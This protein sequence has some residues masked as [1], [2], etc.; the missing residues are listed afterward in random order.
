MFRSQLVISYNAVVE[1][2]DQVER[3]LARPYA[4]A[5]LIFKPAEQSA[6]CRSSC[7]SG[8]IPFNRVVFKGCGGESFA[9]SDHH[10][11]ALVIGKRNVCCRCR[12]V[13]RLYLS[14]VVKR[15]LIC[16]AIGICYRID[17]LIN[18]LRADSGFEVARSIC[19]YSIRDP[20]ISVSEI[21]RNRVCDSSER[22]I[23]RFRIGRAEVIG[24]CALSRGC[25][26]ALHPV[27]VAESSDSVEIK[28]CGNK[29]PGIIRC[30]IIAASNI[31]S[32]ASPTISSGSVCLIITAPVLRV[33]VCGLPECRVAVRDEYNV[34]I[35]SHIFRASS[36]RNIR[37]IL[38]SL[39][40]VCSAFRIHTV[41]SIF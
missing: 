28:T 25:N 31:S 9:Y 32:T 8:H 5:Y 24:A 2:C 26:E 15:D 30:S 41:N 17:E 12:A 19:C 3:C 13:D 4:E 37:R 39:L 6:G 34:L 35:D 14:A 22:S 11:T 7:K 10:G 21:A 16:R 1:V 27:Y 29:R 40:P 38:Q 23:Q 18:I 36:G 33:S 20:D